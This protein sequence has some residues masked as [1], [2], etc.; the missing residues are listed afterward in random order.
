MYCININAS[1]LWIYLRDTRSSRH[2]LE[3]R[4]D[5]LKAERVWR[6]GVRICLYEV[7]FACVVAGDRVEQRALLDR[8]NG[9]LGVLHN[10][11]A[12]TLVR[13][14]GNGES[15][16]MS[17]LTRATCELRSPEP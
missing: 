8:N 11:V 17:Q 16:D 12:R 14:L 3:D 5:E 9:P 10:A 6:I 13:R 1:L 2:V 4:N 7:G 15:P